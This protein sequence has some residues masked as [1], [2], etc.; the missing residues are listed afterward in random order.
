MEHI[1][2]KVF[3]IF[4]TMCL[5]LFL[6]IPLA[7]LYLLRFVIHQETGIKTNYWERP[8]GKDLYGEIKKDKPKCVKTK[9]EGTNAQ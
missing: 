3:N 5:G 2:R 4:A 9:E 1:M 6:L 8:L 7:N